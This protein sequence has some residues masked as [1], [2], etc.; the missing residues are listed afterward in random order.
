MT[1][2]YAWRKLAVIVVLLSLP[3]LAQP[4]SLHPTRALVAWK[5]KATS[6]EWTVLSTGP[7]GS[8]QDNKSLRHIK[9]DQ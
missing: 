6:S 5:A 4:P 2:R 3:A 1:K 9:G 7:T 8:G